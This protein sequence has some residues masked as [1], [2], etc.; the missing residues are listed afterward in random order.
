MNEVYADIMQFVNERVSKISRI[1]KVYEQQEEF[2]KTPT[3]KI[4][5]YLYTNLKN[6]KKRAAS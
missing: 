1:T 2:E 4:K 3:L 5:R 6:N